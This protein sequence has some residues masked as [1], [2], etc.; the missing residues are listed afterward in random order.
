M[1]R[2]LIL[3]LFLIASPV[4]ARQV[5][6]SEDFTAWP[7]PGWSLGAHWT[8]SD[9]SDGCAHNNEDWGEYSLYSPAFSLIPGQE[10][11]LRFRIFQEWAWEWFE[12]YYDRLNVYLSTDG[13]GNWILLGTVAHETDAW[14]EEYFDLSGFS[15]ENCRLRFEHLG[16]GAHGNHIDWVFVEGQ[17]GDPGSL[18][19]PYDECI[20]PTTHNAFCHT[21][22]YWFPNQNHDIARQLSDGIRALMLDVYPGDNG[23]LVYHGDPL[24][25]SDALQDILATVIRPFLESSPQSVLTLLLECYAENEDILEE[26][27]SAGLMPWLHTQVPGQPWPRLEEMI[28]SGQ[29]LLVFSDRDSGIPLPWLHPMWDFCVETHFSNHSIHDFSS[30]FNRGHPDND[31]FILNHFI[32]DNTFG[33]GVESEAMLANANPFLL[34]RSLRVW[35]ETGKRPNFPTLDFY[36]HG[37]VFPL[38]SVL[39]RLETS[40]AV[41]GLLGHWPLD[42]S[43]EDLS[44]IGQR[45]ATAFGVDWVQDAEQGLVAEL[46]GQSDYLRIHSGSLTLP[47]LAM[48]EITVAIRLRP[49]S[50]E[51]WGGYLSCLHD[52]GDYEKGWCLGSR[53]DHYSFALISWS[54]SGLTYLQAPQAALAGEWVHLAGVYDGSTMT[55]YVD[56]QAVASSGEQSGFIDYASDGDYVIGAYQDDDEFFPL[57]G[58]LSDARVYARALSAAEISVLADPSTSAPGSPRI[59]ALSRPWPNPFNPETRLR[60]RVPEGGTTLHVAIYDVR[61]REIRVLAEGF[62]G[63]GIHE[64]QWQ[65][66]DQQ[67]RELGSGVYFCRLRS[68]LFEE[69]R[70][71]ILLR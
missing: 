9:W 48:H 20:F 45:D 24:L 8:W 36:D 7:P 25:G 34:D 38:R 46:D 5:L 15:G 50:F 4:M 56:G 12:Y 69:S 55:L 65:G 22:D 63:E 53:N 52:T 32:T 30:D 3:I 51:E 19:K 57:D 1:K 17:E 29:R 70:K 31:L 33:T 71:L 14:F 11:S 18:E 43:A 49:D 13:G 6:L 66:R 16:G 35:R 41:D 44:I 62:H 42:G 68:G 61:G 10:A 40:D 47:A 37:Q 39:N 64:L 2:R 67:G 58:R 27:S 21:A 23:L 28:A 54:S 26:F 59:L 60:V